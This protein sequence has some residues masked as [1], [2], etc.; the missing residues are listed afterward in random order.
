MPEINKNLN[1]KIGHV[2]THQQRIFCYR[3][4]MRLLEGTKLL[5]LSIDCVKIFFFQEFHAHSG[6]QELF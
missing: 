1:N 3:F 4:G 2:I 6:I 5:H